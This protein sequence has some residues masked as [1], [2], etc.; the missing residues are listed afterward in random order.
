MRLT[1]LD[2]HTIS[3]QL[4][5]CGGLCKSYKKNNGD[6][7]QYGGREPSSLP[8][9]APSTTIATTTTTGMGHC[10]HQARP[11]SWHQSTTAMPRFS[12]RPVRPGQVITQSPEQGSVHD[13]VF[14]LANEQEPVK[15]RKA[16]ERQRLTLFDASLQNTYATTT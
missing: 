4:Y 10:Y 3:R 5:I 14:E 12:P 7:R 2:P 9:T 6:N 1:T 16:R 8:T 15:Q 13:N 11:V